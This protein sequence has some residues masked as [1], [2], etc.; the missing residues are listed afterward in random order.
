MSG[1]Y[2]NAHLLHGVVRNSAHHPH[3]LQRPR[4]R[5]HLNFV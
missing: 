3:L 5:K 1:L 2:V 4:L